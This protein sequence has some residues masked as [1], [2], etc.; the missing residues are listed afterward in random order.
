MSLRDRLFVSSQVFKV[1]RNGFLCILRRFLDRATV[2][3]ATRKERDKY[4]VASLLFGN[5]AD[6][7]SVKLLRLSHIFT[8]VTVSE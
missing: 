8:I 1:K 7:V 4:S 5:Q 2:G 6:L 3:N